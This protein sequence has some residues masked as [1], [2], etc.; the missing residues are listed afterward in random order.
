MFVRQQQKQIHLTH[1]TWSVDLA[2]G[3]GNQYL[4]LRVLDLMEVYRQE[5]KAVLQGEGLL[6]LRRFKDNC[7]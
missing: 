1:S 7:L 5:F 2:T 3:A 4:V 6:K